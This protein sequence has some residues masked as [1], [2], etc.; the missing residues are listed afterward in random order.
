VS[1]DGTIST[2]LQLPES[3]RAELAKPYGP[4][5]NEIDLAGHLRGC[6]RI[7]AIGDVV[8]SNLV[9][10]GIEP[11]LMIFDYHTERGPCGEETKDLLK[12]VEGANIKVQNPPGK[13][14]AEL[15]NAIA[16]TLK[17]GKK[18]KIEVTG[19]EDL[20]SLA[21][22]ALAETGDCVIY[23]IPNEGISVI[24]VDEDIQKVIG[25]VLSQMHSGN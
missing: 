8:S 4:V 1:A 10:M 24:R 2:D 19:E 3:L 11:D 21:C 6:R 23:G 15:W 16:R 17:A 25:G 18:A 5:L 14:T 9:E 12:K 22:I 7:M 13:L 20:A